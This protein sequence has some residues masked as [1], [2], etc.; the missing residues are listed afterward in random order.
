MSTLLRNCHVIAVHDLEASAAWW[1]TALGFE[2]DD[3]DPG[4]WVFMVRDC[5]TIMIGRCPD[6]L[7]ARATGD[8]SYFGYLISDNVDAECKRVK[9]AVK[10]LGGKVFGAPE[11]MPHGMREVACATPEGHRFML[12]QRL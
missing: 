12:A 3:I 1:E 11:D 7:E 2:R 10:M 8:H 5:C 6:A 4:N 9:A